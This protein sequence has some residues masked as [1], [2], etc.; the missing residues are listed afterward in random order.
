MFITPEGLTALI[1]NGLW[2]FSLAI[3]A[4]LL[5]F[6]MFRRRSNPIA[7]LV[8]TNLIAGAL[9]YGQYPL[10]AVQKA[11]FQSADPGYANAARTFDARSIYVPDADALRFAAY[12]CYSSFSQGLC[13]LPVGQLIKSGRLNFIEIGTDPIRRYSIAI[14]DQRCHDWDSF[15]DDPMLNDRH[16]SPGMAACVVMDEVAA[17]TATHVITSTNEALSW[18]SRA[19]YIN[20]QLR[21][22]RANTLIDQFDGWN[23]AAPYL[24]WDMPDEARRPD[25]PLGQLIAIQHDDST[26]DVA[27][28]NALI[29]SHGIDE[30][31]LINAMSSPYQSVQARTIWLACRNGVLASLSADTRAALTVASTGLFVNNPNWRYPRDCPDWMR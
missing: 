9:W 7:W 17:P 11:A 28:D 14:H 3:C 15:L 27:P 10:G 29:A 5:L 31:L 26:Y 30:S 19:R 2:L 16:I 20:V 8:W 22:R 24:V 4:I 21:D 23:R 13:T 25:G 1:T 18:P 12:S 6:A